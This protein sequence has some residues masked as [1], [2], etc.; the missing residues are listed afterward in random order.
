[1]PDVAVS[2]LE[3]M[4]ALI[5]RGADVNAVTTK[6]PR[7]GIRSIGKKIGATP[8]FFAAKGVDLEAMRFLVE[9]GRGC[10]QA[11]R[12]GHDAADGGGRRRHLATSAS[13]RGP[14]RKRS[15]R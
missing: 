9:Q 7:D 14:T 12:R 15:T 6:A 5:E 13:R 10:V 1:M 2:D 11:E 3:L 8:F 4:T